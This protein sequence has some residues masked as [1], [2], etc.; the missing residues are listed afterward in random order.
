MNY[1]DNNNN[2]KSDWKI[3]QAAQYGEQ[4]IKI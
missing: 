4:V 3:V 2:D 1:I